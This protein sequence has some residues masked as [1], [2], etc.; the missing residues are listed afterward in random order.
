MYQLLIV[1][2][3]VSIRHGMAN[4]IPWNQLGFAV[5]GMS[6]DGTEAVEFVESH[7]VDV[8]LSDIRMP[9]MDGVELMEYLNQNH[10]QIKIVILSGYSDFEYLNKSIKNHVAEYL[11]KPTDYDEFE[12]LFRKLKRNLDQEREQEREYRLLKQSAE[13]YSKKDRE[14]MVRR[15]IKGNSGETDE[16][17]GKVLEEAG[18][19]CDSCVLLLCA[20]HHGKTVEAEEVCHEINRFDGGRKAACFQ[21]TEEE[22]LAFITVLPGEE[23]SVVLE[24]AQEL[25][26][27]IM[28]KTGVLLSMGISNLCS[29]VR[30]IP[31]CYRQAECSAMQKIFSNQSTIHLY[32]EIREK[33]FQYYSV[34]FDAEVMEKYIRDNDKE[35]IAQEIDRV[36]QAF[37]NNVVMAFHYADR[38]C[39]EFLFNISRWMF[40]YGFTLEQV[41]GELGCEYGD[42]YQYKNLEGKKT[43]L[44]KILFALM[45]R[46]Q[47][48]QDSSRK[49]IRLGYAIREYLDRE[50]C[51]NSLSLDS[52]AMKLDKN[53]A[54]I[55]KVFKDETGEKFS[56]YITRKR[57]EKGMELLRETDL[58][59]YVIADRIG[60]ADASGFIKVFKKKY[61]ISPAEY[62]ARFRGGQ[63]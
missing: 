35:K 2:D 38:I 4:S 49:T 42:L 28:E 62:R 32:E 13:K 33:E 10:P 54:Y 47:K 50:Y 26:S 22:L 46:L 39:L 16:Y 18:V 25:Q 41:M 3:E 53:A 57:L 14:E 55:S 45:E 52:V 1:D 44:S 23:L 51:S 6:A 43:V 11:L 60:Y 30:M 63:T 27:L 17:A 40:R 61:S 9:K 34:Y 7:E 56:D 31:Q 48:Y 19:V 20:L 29:D 24:Y 58:K 59:I 21:L 12:E 36:F 5:A 8:V 37:E 15:M